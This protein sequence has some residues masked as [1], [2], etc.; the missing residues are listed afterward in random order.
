MEDGEEV[1]GDGHEGG[2]EDEEAYLVLHDVV[3]PASLHLC[4]SSVRVSIRIPTTSKPTPPTPSVSPRELESCERVK[5]EGG[6][7][8]GGR[9]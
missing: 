6:Q 1:D 3:A 4:Y 5:G 7:G 9:G 2:V 8:G